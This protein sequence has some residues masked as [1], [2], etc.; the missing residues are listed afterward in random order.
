[1][2]TKLR[3]LVGTLGGAGIFTSIPIIAFTAIF[4]INGYPMTSREAIA[5]TITLLLQW[6]LVYILFGRYEDGQ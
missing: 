4:W 1:M 5:V 2:E 6:R 3:K